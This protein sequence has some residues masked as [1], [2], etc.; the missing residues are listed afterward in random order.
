MTN[1]LKQVIGP[2]THARNS[3]LTLRKAGWKIRRLKR[4]PAA[5]DWIFDNSSLIKEQEKK[6]III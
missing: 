3:L 5:K 2:S 6:V 1:R 4:K